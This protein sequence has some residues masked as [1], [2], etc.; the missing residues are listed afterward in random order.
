MAGGASGMVANF[1]S[2]DWMWNFNWHWTLQ[3][4][5]WLR[6]SGCPVHLAREFPDAGILVTSIMPEEFR[7]GRNLFVVSIVGDGSPEPF[8]QMHVVQNRMQT[9]LVSNSHYVPFWPQ[10]GLIG[11]DPA[12]GDAFKSLAY[13]GDDQNIAPELRGEEWS[14]FL[15]ARGIEW[16]V[17]DARS[18]RNT[19]FSDIDA[20]IG[21]RSFQRTG[22]VRKP[23]SKLINAW[24]AGVPSILGREIAFREQ[25]LSGVD[26]LEAASF[27]RACDA[28]DQLAASPDLRRAMVENG[29]RRAAAFTVPRIISRWRHV[30]FDLA[31]T[32]AARWS[33]SSPA[34]RRLFFFRRQ[35]ERKSR[36]VVH[37]ALRA[38]GQEQYAM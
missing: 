14:R 9:R 17:R 16:H 30:L 23:A 34:S 7:P 21:V 25:R 2:S 22:Y 38:V 27:A 10:P 18:S 8:A 15:G 32:A 11:R 20:V 28:V 33:G 29:Q 5:F 13:F 36:G 4:Y 31:Q 19:D 37:R 1:Q 24:I 26:Y 12:R 35:L 3:T 6:E